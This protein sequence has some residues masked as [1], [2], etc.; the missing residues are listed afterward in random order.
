M[1]VGESKKSGVYAAIFTAGMAIGGVGG[2]QID[3]RPGIVGYVEAASV[4][5]ITGALDDKLPK[6]RAAQLLELADDIAADVTDGETVPVSGLALR[7]AEKVRTDDP[8]WLVWYGQNFAP[9]LQEQITAGHAAGSFAL[10]DPVSVPDVVDAMQRTA[11]LHLG[12]M[13]IEAGMSV[14]RAQQS[15]AEDARL[16]GEL[17]RQR[18]YAE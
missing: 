3:N 16:K 13:P 14:V 5:T 12:T 15:L 18:G 17:N 8:A 1:K 11:K 9:D 7:L 6:V 10:E 4:Q 2:A